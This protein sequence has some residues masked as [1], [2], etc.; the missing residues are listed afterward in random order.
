MR[1]YPFQQWATNQH[2][3]QK[4]AHFFFFFKWTLRRQRQDTC[5]KMI[6]VSLPDTT[7]C[8]K[9]LMAFIFI[10]PF[11]LITY[12]VWDTSIFGG[13]SIARSSFRRLKNLCIL[14]IIIIFIAPSHKGSF[15]CHGKQESENLTIF[16]L[17]IWYIVIFFLVFFVMYCLTLIHR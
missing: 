4:T 7:K 6:S 17:F 10:L 1:T 13:R 2:I 9:W 15:R 11:F 12:Q 8:K 3:D 5:L 16:F 14:F